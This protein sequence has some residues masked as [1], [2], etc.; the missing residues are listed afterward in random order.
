[1]LQ[2]KI[3]ASFPLS[4]GFS[5][6]L[7]D[8]T[9]QRPMGLCQVHGSRVLCADALTAEKAEE[10]DGLWTMTSGLRIGVRVADCVPILL[11]GLAHGRPWVAALHGG[12]RGVVDGILAQGVR[13]FEAQG[14]H[15]E[16]LHYAF[17]P[18]IQA[19]CFEVGPEVV[20]AASQDPAWHSELAFFQDNGKAMLD[21]HGLLRA[22]ARA[23]GLS[24]DKDGSL[25]ICTKCHP[26]LLYSYRRGDLKARQ[27]GWAEIL[28]E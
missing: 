11:S 28:S 7:D 26:E 16:D 8:L 15:A 1:M 6:R 2:P 24:Q 20:E 9:F 21:L 10:A 12:W 14:G 19:C 17:G 13:A 4:W 25:P 5:T 27:W 23:L 22:Q 18:S 3:Q